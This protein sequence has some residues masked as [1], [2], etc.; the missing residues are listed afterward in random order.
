VSLVAEAIAAAGGKGFLALTGAGCSTESGIPDYRSPLGVYRRPDFKPLTASRFLSSEEER[1]RYWARSMMGYSTVSGAVPNPSHRALD[2]LCRNGWVRHVVT[3]N[4][5]GLHHAAANGGAKAPGDETHLWYTTSDTPLTELHGNI[6]MARCIS[7]S[8]KVPRVVLQEQLVAANKALVDEL[9]SANTRALAD[10][11]AS[12]PEGNVS[13]MQLI[14]C[15]SCGGVLRPDVVLFGE[16]VP[17]PV[18]HCVYDHVARCSALV[19]CGTSLQVYSALR[20]VEA[21]RKA[22]KPVIIVNHGATRADNLASLKI[23]ETSIAG[24]LE[25]LSSHLG[26]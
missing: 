16:N 4:V 17:T 6:H 8:A 20:F 1:K 12:L 2:A 7:C 11:D 10:G 19:C 24:F 22:G 5:D 18:V 9:R 13:R 15:P 14:H 23:D 26:P 25:E 21:A 3:Q